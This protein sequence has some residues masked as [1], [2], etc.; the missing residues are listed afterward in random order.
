VRYLSSLI[1]IFPFLLF[2]SKITESDKKNK[3]IILGG[4][5]LSQKST[6]AYICDR[7]VTCRKY[8]TSYK[9]ENNNY[10]CLFDSTT[11]QHKCNLATV[12][13]GGTPGTITNYYA[14]KSD[15]VDES[16]CIGLIKKTRYTYVSITTIDQPYTFTNQGYPLKYFY[17]GQGTT[18]AAS[19]DRIGRPLTT[20]KLLSMDGCPY[21]LQ[22]R[23]DD[24]NLKVSADSVSLSA[25]NFPLN[26][27][28]ESVFNQDYNEI[29]RGYLIQNSVGTVTA[30]ETI[31]INSTAEI[32]K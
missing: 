26:N 25:C 28:H 3:M 16:A 30:A 31:T 20:E 29:Q 24:I 19:W 6:P 18:I 11:F 15:F 2:C 8:P 10:N 27:H 4:I 21:Y 22:Y 12:F 5:L 7:K 1:L 23:Y 32:C 9:T 14:S 17:D 13:A